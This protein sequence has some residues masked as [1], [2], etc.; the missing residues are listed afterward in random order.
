MPL[1]S[2]LGTA[3]P[4]TRT[5]TLDRRYKKVSKVVI[6]VPSLRI[7]Y[8]GISN[9]SIHPHNIRNMPNTSSMIPLTTPEPYSIKRKLF[10]AQG[11]GY[12]HDDLSLAICH[13]GL[14]GNG[15]CE[16]QRCQRMTSKE[17]GRIN[18]R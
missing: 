4:K 18:P 10:L 16:M 8:L 12:D 14:R 3:L 11:T 17:D 5:I 15:Y 2:R 1:L 13:F 9:E 7:V 6:F